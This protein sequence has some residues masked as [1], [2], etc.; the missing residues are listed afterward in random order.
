M[1]PL[2][3]T[4]ASVLLLVALAGCGERAASPPASAPAQAAEKETAHNDDPGHE[5]EGIELDEAEIKSAGIRVEV[6]DW[7]PR[8]GEI[9]V[10]GVIEPNLDLLAQVAPRVPGRIVQVGAA[11]GDRV[12]SGQALAILESFEI[13]E[14]RATY[15]QSEA[16]LKVADAAFRRA[17]NLRAD[18]IVPEKEF[19]RTR[20]DLD[21]ARAAAAT[22]RERLRMLGVG[23]EQEGGAAS[24]FS[25]L[26]PF[27]GTVIEKSAVRGA[28][29]DPG[30]ALFTVADLG[31]LWIVADVFERDLP[32]LVRGAAAMV[33][34]QAWQGTPS[35]GRVTYV[36]SV[37][38]RETR[39]VKARVEVANVDG[40]LRPG[41]FANV[42]ITVPDESAGK[43]LQVPEDA[44]LLMDGK[45]TVFVQG[46]H[47]FEAR[48]VATGERL[49][50]R[51]VLNDGVAAG[52][53]VVVAGA[54]E[55]KARMQK[56]KLGEGRAH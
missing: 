21:K 43:A 13:G 1:T 56:S 4:A 47:G 48:A 2:H 46:G 54:Y 17:E 16:E 3:S 49:L 36:A 37:M 14:A 29:A 55:L 35:K 11:L 23:L 27:G 26:A 24:Q 12:A 32:R 44:V 20:G 28:L 52:E 33:T 45:S 18:N 31:T 34:V 53:R 42:A 15:Q 40:R 22:A 7:V 5:A 39:T 30:K 25:V 38:D 50:G 41:M 19:L 9:A 10:T 6:I 51:V 8:G